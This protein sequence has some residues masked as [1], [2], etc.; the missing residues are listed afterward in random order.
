ME[1]GERA[2][3]NH[4]LVRDFIKKSIS[5]LNPN[6]YIVFITPDNVFSLA[7][8]NDV[9]RMLTSLKI[10]H[11]ELNTAKKKWF[12]KVG[13]SFAWYVVKNDEHRDSYYTCSGI[14]KKK[15]F[16]SK[17]KNHARDYIPLLWTDEVKEL[18][19]KT[20]D[21][22]TPKLG[23]E[24]SSDLHAFTKRSL[25]TDVIDDEHPWRIIH[26]PKQTKYSSRAHKYQDGWKVFISLTDTY[27]VWKDN[28]GMTQ[29]V[30]FIRT[31][32]EE[33]ADRICELLNKP[34][35]KYINDIHRYGNF[36]SIRIL[37][38]FPKAIENY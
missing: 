27:K 34:I 13:S 22:K 33:E 9:C 6:G 37:Q 8:R 28:C 25:L 36:N 10:V 26:T 30:A 4:T 14:Y 12:P 7:D 29:S 5:I 38:K 2:S 23:V 16:T 11:M 18:L 19:N 31:H 35:F 24:T 20:I 32:D 3:K 17:I 1:N 15:E 21:S